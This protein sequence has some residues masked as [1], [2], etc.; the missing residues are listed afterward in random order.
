MEVKKHYAQEAASTRRFLHWI[1]VP[2]NRL[3]SLVEE[4]RTDMV[5]QKQ[6]WEDK[7]ELVPKTTQG[8]K[9]KTLW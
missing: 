7:V 4:G 1:T 3:Y 6:W 5:H 2:K 8:E 9:F